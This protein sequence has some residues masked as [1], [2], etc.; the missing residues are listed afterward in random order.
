M[1]IERGKRILRNAQSTM[2]DF[3][4][5][6]EAQ[7]NCES[8]NDIDAPS[9]TDVSVPIDNPPTNPELTPEEK[10]NVL[11]TTV[12]R[13]PLNREILYKTLAFCSTERPL[14][15]AEEYI[16]SLPQF[17]LATQNQYAMLMSLVK[18]HGLELIERDE[19]GERVYP[20]QKVGL[21]EDEIDDL[22]ASISF[23]NTSVGASFVSHNEPRARLTDLFDLTPER[24]DAYVE[25]LEFIAAEPRSYAQI[26]SLLRGRPVLQTVIDGRSE[27]MQPSVFVDKLGRAG[28]LVWKDGWVLTEEGREFLEDLKTSK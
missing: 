27:T 5:Q 20:D 22:V 23:K 16:A 15:E 9:L 10:L 21:T 14:R 8:T 6:D 25:L 19:E 2:T 26:D 17:P 24:A 1:P 4:N 3:H 28:A 7:G 11:G 13:H 12:M 18:A